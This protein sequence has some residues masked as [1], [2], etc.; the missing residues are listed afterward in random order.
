MSEKSL[1]LREPLIVIAGVFLFLTAALI[2]VGLIWLLKELKITKDDV[3]VGKA[4]IAA[5]VAVLPGVI[6]LIIARGRVTPVD[7]KTGKVVNPAVK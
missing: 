6:G 5:L 2:F 4:F 3:A 7:P 1:S